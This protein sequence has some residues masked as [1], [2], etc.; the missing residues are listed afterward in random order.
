MA[1]LSP[2]SFYSILS[3]VYYTMIALATTKKETFALGNHIANIEVMPYG[4]L[5][6][7]AVCNY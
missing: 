6:S 7:V 1:L 5:H 2:A 4:E 3:S